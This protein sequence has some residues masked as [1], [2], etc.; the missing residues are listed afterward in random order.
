M[1][2][3]GTAPSSSI[4]RT[5]SNSKNCAGFASINSVH[6][7]VSRLPIQGRCTWRPLPCCE[8]TTPVA[9]YTCNASRKM[10]L[11]TL[12]ISIICF[13]VGRFFPELRQST[14]S[15]DNCDS[16]LLSSS[17]NLFMLIYQSILAIIINSRINYTLF[18]RKSKRQRYMTSLVS[19]LTSLTRVGLNRGEK[20]YNPY[21]TPD[22]VP[23]GPGS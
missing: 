11:L 15:A 18:S 1:I 21:S 6:E 3:L 9:S 22:R 12:N 2:I 4:N 13:S 17:C 19:C 7:L 16:K 20:E 10:N 23:V 14:M 5:S 8:T